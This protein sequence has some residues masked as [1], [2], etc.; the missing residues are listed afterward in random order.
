M[1]LI[2]QRL[3][4]NFIKNGYFPTDEVTLRRILS[5]L[6]VD[7]TQ[8]RILDPCCGEGVALAEVGNHL[9]EAGADVL[10]LG[11]EFDRE[12]AWHAKNLLTRVVHSDVHDV[13][14]SP[15]SIGL[16]FLNPPY[17][18]VV[19]DK[20]QTG[21]KTKRERL[22]KIFFRKTI[23]T[24]V[25]GGVM[26]L[27]VPHTV[28]DEEF[29]G[30]IAR[31]FDRVSFHMAPETRFKQ[32]VIF[33]IK[34]RAEHPSKAVADRL[35]QGGRGELSASILPEDWSEEPYRVPTAGDDAE[36]QLYAVRIDGPQLQ[37]E[38]E[39][40]MRQTLWPQFPTLFVHGSKPARPPLRDMSQW[41]LAL[42]LAAGQV[43][44][45]VKSK[46]GRVLLIKG[47]TFKEKS[48][49]VEH[50]TDADGNVT[51]IRT[52]TDTFIPVIRGID[53]TPGPSLGQIVTIR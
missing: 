16:L 40:F 5:A 19:S 28:I 30:M 20:A 4:H 23:P 39:R 53:F 3:A 42:A 22:E 1:A 38:L 15:R 17:G 26:I 7:G 6:D 18:D 31:H 36:F 49:A 21:D 8:V 51:E 48:K 34:K 50:Q 32:C 44:G 29:A 11:I 10:S 24:L 14:V 43:C 41:H 46:G 27:I 12:R 37:A 35:Q 45:I 25:F 9:A 13:V 52:L 33:G 2:F 47:D